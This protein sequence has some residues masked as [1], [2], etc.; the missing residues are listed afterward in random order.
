MLYLYKIIDKYPVFFNC[1][2]FSQLFSDTWKGER[3]ICDDKIEECNRTILPVQSENTEQPAESTVL[4]SSSN[5]NFQMFIVDNS[6]SSDVNN[7]CI[8]SQNS[9]TLAYQNSPELASNVKEE[10]VDAYTEFQDSTQNSVENN[11]SQTNAFPPIVYGNV[12]SNNHNRTNMEEVT[13]SSILNKTHVNQEK[14][15]FDSTP[16]M[17]LAPSNNV[18]QI[19][20]SGN[21]GVNSSQNMEGNST[22]HLFSNQVSVPSLQT[23]NTTRT[24]E[25]DKNQGLEPQLDST[26]CRSKCFDILKDALQNT[27]ST[28]YNVVC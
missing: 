26:E 17:V 27:V 28:G 20:L 9:A 12:N 25:L 18:Q 8:V 11:D 14:P 16:M 10:P 7:S 23:T 21:M 22:S 4:P 24:V 1:L 3:I 13:S 15:T 5:S 2:F 6:G 19:I